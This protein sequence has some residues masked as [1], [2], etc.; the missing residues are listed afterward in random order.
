MDASY[1]SDICEYKLVKLKFSSGSHFDSNWYPHMHVV[2]LV[3][4]S[5]DLTG[6]NTTEHLQIPNLHAHLKLHTTSV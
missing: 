3:M 1:S 2:I 5:C 4:Q 6:Q